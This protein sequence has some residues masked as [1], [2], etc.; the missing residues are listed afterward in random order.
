MAVAGQAAL[1]GDVDEVVGLEALV[2][3]TAREVRQTRTLAG[4]LIAVG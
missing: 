2:A 4:D 1:E 3:E